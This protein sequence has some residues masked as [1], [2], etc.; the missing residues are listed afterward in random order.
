MF[1]YV[2]PLTA[3]LKV[4]QYER[5]RAVYCGLCRA[6]GRVTGQLSRITL[7]Y[8]FTFYAALRHILEGREPVFAPMRCPAHPLNRRLTVRE[9]P[10]LGFSAAVS[11]AF[12][13]AKTGDDLRDE[14][15]LSR[16]RPLA[17]RPL[18]AAMDKRAGDLLPPDADAR[19]ASLLEALAGREREN[20]P[21]LDETAGLFG[22]AL[23]YAFSLGLD[24]EAAALARSLGRGVGRFVYVCDAADDLTDDVKRGR[25][26]PI[27]AGWGPMAL[28]DGRLSPMVKRSLAASV[29]IG[30]EE[31]GEA[32]ERLD[33]SHILTPI[34]KNIIYL[35]LPASLGRVL[36]G[37]G[38]GKERL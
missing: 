17:R 4:S 24:G 30:L 11:A 13:H 25:Y 23:A 33:A 10:T 6:M 27:A 3:E 15:G 5:Y 26:N 21:S 19:I 29:P 28:E 12:A 7:S 35:G 2:R 18:T 9:N 38:A 20:C 36:D 16:V 31:A 34:V 37:K 22:E 8:D 14:R 32:A 1:G